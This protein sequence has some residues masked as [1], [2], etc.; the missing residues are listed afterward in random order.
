MEYKTLNNGV[1][2]PCIGFGTFQMRGQECIEAV[3]NAIKF[4]Y[5]LVDTAEGYENEAEVGIGIARAIADGLVK[6]E[7]LIIGTK[8]SVHHPI[9]YEETLKSF[10]K[11]LR[12]LNLDYLDIYL[13]HYPNAMADD[14]W[15]RLNADTYR[16]M[17]F[18]HNQG[19]LRVLGVSNFMIYHIE[20]LLKTAKIKPAINQIE[21]SPTWQQREVVEYCKKNNITLQAWQPI[22]PIHKDWIKNKLFIQQMPQKYGKTLAQIFLNYSFQK[23]Y[24]PLVK[25]IDKQRMIENIQSFDFAIDN[26]DIGLLDSL[27]CSTTICPD[28]SH[29]LWSLHEALHNKSYCKK[30]VYRL[31]GFIPLLKVKSNGK[32]KKTYLLFCFIKLFEKVEINYNHNRLYLLGFIPIAKTKKYYAQNII[33]KYI[34]NYKNCSLNNEQKVKAPPP[35]N[36]LKDRFIN[37]IVVRAEFWKE[38]YQKIPFFKYYLWFRYMLKRKISIP[39][40]DCHITTICNLKCKNCSHY[41]PYYKSQNKYM[42]SVEKFKSNI[43]A[44]LENVDLI[45]NLNILGGEPLLNKDMD[46]ILE[47]ANSKPQIKA[48]RIH[49]NGT[50]LPSKDLIKKII[51]LNKVSV[52]LSNYSGNPSIKILKDEKIIELFDKYKVKYHRA[53]RDYTWGLVPQVNLEQDIS[54]EQNIRQYLKCNFKYCPCL[55]DGKIYPCALAKHIA[56]RGY[57]LK[58]TDCIDLSTDKSIRKDFINFYKRNSFEICKCCDFTTYGSP[59]MPAIQI[60]K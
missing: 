49:T 47:Y 34:P 36:L 3:Y 13:I 2:I 37:A 59:I 11:S 50:I 48:I 52:F 10:N 45:Y 16:A 57:H 22:A 29:H 35:N 44:I 27:Q 41:I 43:D 28:I 38:K 5:R 39:S 14:S 30:E 33:I 51:S 55:S 4:G 6:R 24:I 23:G 53:P 60:E 31:F 21:L 26:S 17:E 1:Q 15:K 9:G 12:K 7:D 32:N 56:D 54:D 46:K 8:L 20:E 58:D 18:L 25:T 42:L 19:L 40:L